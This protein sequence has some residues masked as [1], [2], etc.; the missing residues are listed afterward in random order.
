MKKTVALVIMDGF[1]YSD[2]TIGH[3]IATAETPNID[4]FQKTLKNSAKLLTFL[5]KYSLICKNT[6]IYYVY[7]LAHS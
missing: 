5:E 6:V 2:S 3:A 4:N 7:R 1:G